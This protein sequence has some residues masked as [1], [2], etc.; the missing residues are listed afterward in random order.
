MEVVVPDLG[1]F[2]DVEVIEVLV[3]PGDDVKVEQGLVTLETEKATMDVPSTAAGVVKSLALKKGDRVSKGVLI[4]L[5]EGG[6]APAAK[7]AP[8][9]PKA[10][11]AKAA[12]AAPAAAPTKKEPTPARAAASPAPAATKALPQI[13]EAGFA[14]AYA[15]PSVRKFARELGADLSRIKG[16]GPKDRITPDDVKAGRPHRTGNDAGRTV[17]RRKRPFAVDPQLLIAVP[18]AADVVVVGVDQRR[19]VDGESELL[20]NQL[21]SGPHDRQ[22]I[23]VGVALGPGGVGQIGPARR[24]LGIE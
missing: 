24:R 4:G 7:S 3:K 1:D 18:L 20:E 9:G 6:A 5:L 21:G 13:D 19:L 11:P 8:E 22:P 12:A 14:R 15:S 23:G 17:V 16:T 10:E 2:A